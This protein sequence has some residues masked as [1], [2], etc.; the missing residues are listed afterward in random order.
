MRS[1]RFKHTLALSLAA[2]FF[3]IPAQANPSDVALVAK[4][5]SVS[6]EGTLLQYNDGLFHVRTQLGEMW[7]SSEVY[8]C[9][10][11]ACPGPTAIARDTL[12]RS[13]LVTTSP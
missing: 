4:D 7:L 13:L 1:C 5:R 11:A 6:V 2:F 3:A 10:G 9:K 8:T 12:V